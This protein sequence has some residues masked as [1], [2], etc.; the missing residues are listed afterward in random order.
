M[1]N[2]SDVRQPANQRDYIYRRLIAITVYVILS[3]VLYFLLA[4]QIANHEHLQARLENS[5]FQG[6]LAY[7]LIYSAQMFIPWLPGAPLDIIGG[8]IFGFWQTT[9]LS[10]AAASASGLII[11]LMVRR[12]GL[13]TIVVRFPG[14][15]ES[16]WRLVQIIKRQ[17]WALVAVNML[18]GDAAYFVAGSAGI[19]AAFA[20]GL[21]AVMRIPSVMIGTAIGAGVVSSAIR[22][23][24]D[25]MVAVASIVTVTGLMVGFAI[26]RR[27]LPGWLQHLEKSADDDRSAS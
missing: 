4:P 22:Q 11:Y 23:K 5:G 19:P 16:P 8:A 21:L 1:Q 14:L 24:L 6:V 7:L 25:I 15:M 27:Y 20:I 12:V 2:Q 9:V 13:E 10:T 17:P 18:T 3:V 26:A